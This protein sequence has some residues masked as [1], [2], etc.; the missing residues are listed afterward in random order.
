MPQDLTWDI[1][2][3]S[4]L[5]DWQLWH[6]TATEAIKNNQSNALVCHRHHLCSPGLGLNLIYTHPSINTCIQVMHMLWWAS[7]TGL[8]LRNPSFSPVSL[9]CRLQMAMSE[10]LQFGDTGSTKPEAAGQAGE[11]QTGKDNM[12]TNLTEGV[13]GKMCK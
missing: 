7:R 3:T 9:N 13:A 5:L 2:E 12:V 1:K 8:A 10:R 11:S 4:A 6:E